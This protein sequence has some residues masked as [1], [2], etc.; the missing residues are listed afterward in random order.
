LIELKGRDIESACK[1]LEDSFV[2]PKICAI[3]NG[4]R[5]AIVVSKTVKIPQ[6]DYFDAKMKQKFASKYKARFLVERHQKTVCPKK[7]CGVSG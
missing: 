2:H 4:K 6:F 5:A 7:C 3:L 1:Q